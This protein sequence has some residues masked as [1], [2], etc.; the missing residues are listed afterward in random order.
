M[1]ELL[2]KYNNEELKKLQKVE[3]EILKE[4]I[5]VSDENS[6]AWFTVVGTTLGAV[7][8]NGFKPEIMT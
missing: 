6:I 2:M 1:S 4:V 3:I 5:R 8:Y 7:R